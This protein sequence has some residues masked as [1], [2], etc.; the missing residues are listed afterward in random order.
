[1]IIE[2]LPYI[3]EMDPAVMAPVI[4]AREDL[5]YQKWSTE[6]RKKLQE[7]SDSGEV[8]QKKS[9]IS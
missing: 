3:A 4:R 5:A 1:M 6:L 2:C 8:G 7:D 9:Q